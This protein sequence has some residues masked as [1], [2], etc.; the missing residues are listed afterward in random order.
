MNKIYCIEK[1]A[2]GGEIW[3][4]KEG[5]IVAEQTPEWCA[6]RDRVEKRERKE[7]KKMTEKIRLTTGRYPA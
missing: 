5:N 1:T 6:Y 2:N 3:R 7:W 4:D